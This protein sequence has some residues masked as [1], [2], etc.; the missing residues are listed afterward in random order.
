MTFSDLVPLFGAPQMRMSRSKYL[1][2]QLSN[3]MT[4]FAVTARATV[5]WLSS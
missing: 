4:R 2:S 1:Y 3:K 5:K